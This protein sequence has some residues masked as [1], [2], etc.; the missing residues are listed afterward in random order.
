MY[1]MHGLG[2]G[3]GLDVHDPEQ[4]YYTGKIDI[5][6]AVTLDPGIYVRGNLLETLPDTPRNQQLAEKLRSA[7]QRFANV[8]V[9]IEDDYVATAN[10]VEW[11][12]RAPR[13]AD[14]VE[15]L[16]KETFAG[17]APRDRA[18]VDWYRAT[19]RKRSE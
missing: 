18:K 5:G 4:F 19:E 2:H 14:E 9:R 13:E 15:A 12:S 3:I 17:P 1:Y 7:V 10:G 6:S 11:I 8:G 16:M